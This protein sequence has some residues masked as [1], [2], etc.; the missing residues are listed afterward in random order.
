MANP[1]YIEWLKPD[2]L[3]R[4]TAWARD[5]LTDEQIA[6]NMGINVSTLYK[7]KNDNSEINDA[8]KKGKEVVDIQVENALFKRAIGYTVTLEKDFKLKEVVYDNNGKKVCEKEYLQMGHEQ[9]H[10]PAD[11]TAQIFWLKNRKA[12][13][14]RDKQ[15]VEH[16]GEIKN[17]T[18]EVLLAALKERKVEGLNDE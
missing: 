4:L 10:V 9:Q 16:S 7:W 15:D 11:T 3:L 6:N 8:L 13:V 18:H 2:N 5:G 17:A 1:K 14:W 12:A